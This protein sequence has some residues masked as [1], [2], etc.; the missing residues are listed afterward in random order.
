MQGIVDQLVA[1]RVSATTFAI[2]VVLALLLSLA[3]GALAGIKLAGNDLGNELAAMMG[4]MFGPTA[5]VP[6]IVVGLIVLALL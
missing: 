6:G 3:G 2:W 4:A 5:A 1:G